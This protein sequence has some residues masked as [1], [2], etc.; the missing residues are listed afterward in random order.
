MATQ[1][2]GVRWITEAY[3]KHIT[4]HMVPELS[5]GTV[6]QWPNLQ[7][8]SNKHQR[9]WKFR[10]L[11]SLCTAAEET[12]Y[13][14]NLRHSLQSTALICFYM[15]TPSFSLLPL[16]HRRTDTPQWD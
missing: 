4:T 10:Q 16:I 2:V 5:T 1:C 3:I 11:D 14:V 12:S 13:S 7:L 9:N 6:A 8:R 15:H